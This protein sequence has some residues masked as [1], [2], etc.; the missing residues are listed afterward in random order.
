MLKKGTVRRLNI[1]TKLNILITSLVLITSVVIGLFVVRNEKIHTYQ[2]LVNHGQSVASMIAQNSEYGIYTEDDHALQ[3]ITKG[4]DGDADIIF[5]AVLDKENKVL[6]YREK[7]PFRH[8]LKALNSSVS[9]NPDGIISEDFI[10][11]EDQRSYITIVAPVISDVDN[12][13]TNLIFEDVSVPGPELIGYVRLGLTREGIRK[14]LNQFLISTMG[15]TSV[16]VLLGIG[17]TLF[18]TKKI[19]HPINQLS[20][21]TREISEGNLDH[22]IEITTSDEIADLADNFNHM[23][24]HLRSYRS[25]VEERTSEL[26]ESRERYALAARGANDGLWDWDLKAHEIYYSPRWKSMLGFE[27]NEIGRSTIRSWIGTGST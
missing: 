22:S 10:Y 18:T 25:Q 11:S 3:Q 15:F 1:K 16:L 2:E 9:E 14:R 23:I 24:V 21:V 26:I 20:T 12:I 17:L 7:K 27:E 13:T 19:T 5:V 6:A 4:I 8:M